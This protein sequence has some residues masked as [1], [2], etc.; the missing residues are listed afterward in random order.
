MADNVDRYRGL[1]F[2][3]VRAC[4]AKEFD[5]ERM[6]RHA[7]CLAEVAYLTGTDCWEYRQSKVA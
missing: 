2:L 5:H 6:E 4:Q 1:N 3:E 7:I